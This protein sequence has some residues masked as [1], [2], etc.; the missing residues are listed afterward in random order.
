ML[1]MFFRFL[2]D[3]LR[4]GSDEEGDP[5]VEGSG[6]RGGHRSFGGI[7]RGEKNDCP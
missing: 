3:R 1:D 4:D 2:A 7:S 5:D 6:S